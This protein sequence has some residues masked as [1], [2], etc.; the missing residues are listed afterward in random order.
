VVTGQE[1]RE[2][3][4]RAVAG[5]ARQARPSKRCSARVR[6]CSRSSRRIRKVATTDTPVLVAGETGTGKEL[7][8]RAIYRL[9]HRRDGPFV[10]TNCGAIPENL[11]EAELFGHKKRFLPKSKR[12]GRAW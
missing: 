12:V 9:S 7:A 8:A 2:N 6:R 4:L 5:A 11:L 3:A 10:A 1:K